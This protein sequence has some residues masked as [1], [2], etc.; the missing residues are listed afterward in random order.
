MLHSI[1]SWLANEMHAE[2]TEVRE[3]DI[4]QALRLAVSEVKRSSEGYAR[5]L[6][7]SDLELRERG[8]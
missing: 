7:A 3:S 5:A 6:T 1:V 4:R 2:M 8:I